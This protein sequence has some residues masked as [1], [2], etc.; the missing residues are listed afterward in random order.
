MFQQNE[1]INYIALFCFSNI[2]V[3]WKFYNFIGSYSDWCDK[4]TGACECRPGVGGPKCDR[5]EPGYWGLPKISSG[6]KGCLRKHTL[7]LS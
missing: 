5:C 3:S 1:I 7:N 2:I 4:E 6:Y